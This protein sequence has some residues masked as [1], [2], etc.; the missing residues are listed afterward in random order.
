MRVNTID[1]YILVAC[2]GTTFLWPLKKQNPGYWLSASTD[3]QTDHKINNLTT[4]CTFIFSGG[5]RSQMVPFTPAS[6]VS[7]HLGK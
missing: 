5:S 1:L 6:A 3:K 4:D 2:G 7:G